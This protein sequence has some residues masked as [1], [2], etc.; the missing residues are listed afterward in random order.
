MRTSTRVALAGLFVRTILLTLLA[1]GTTVPVSA[2]PEPERRVALVIG[3]SDYRYTEKLRNPVNDATQIAE[4][5]RRLSFTVVAGMDL[6]A[7]Q[8]DAK[9][10]AFAQAVV[11]ADV[12]LV[13]YAGHG[14]QVGGQNYLMPIDA[15]IA[16]ERSAVREL[17]A[18]GDVMAEVEAKAKATLVFLDSC[19]NNPLQKNIQGPSGPRGESARGLARMEDRKNANTLLMFATAP[20]RT[21]EDGLSQHSPFTEA[22]LPHIEA[23]NIDVEVM[24]KRVVRD[25]LLATNDQQQ[26]ERLS[27]LR[28]EFQ[29]VASK[30]A[31]EPLTKQ[32]NQVWARE[33]EEYLQLK[34]STDV[35]LV[36]AFIDK[37]PGGIYAD[38]ARRR[39]RE[40]TSGPQ[41]P[42]APKEDPTL[43]CTDAMTIGTPEAYKRFI[44]KY[45]TH[46][47]ADRFRRQMM[48]GADNVAW[49][50]AERANSISEYERYKDLF[51][52]GLRVPIAKDR[53]AVLLAK[54]RGQ[55]I[56]AER[57][58][59]IPPVVSSGTACT[60][61]SIITWLERHGAYGA[62]KVDTSVY[63]DPVKWVVNG[64]ESTKS[65]EELSEDEVNF[66]N[67]FPI[68]NYTLKSA[69]TTLAQ[70]RC[71]MVMHVDSYK[72]R[73][74]GSEERTSLKIAFGIRLG[75]DG[76]LIVEQHI[77]VLRR[78]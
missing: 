75:M 61:Q 66:R 21:A 54:E 73:T 24:L 14:I 27:K 28:T 15:R 64:D 67:A 34:D 65:R 43:E 6:T 63:L 29:F 3:N 2:A 70:E 18:L 8:M 58:P 62:E 10:E 36:A 44:T 4:V 52:E 7:E 16:N 56:I 31:N 60:E 47:C 59:T 19:R 46:S 76:P 77:D 48:I 45:P 23:P 13:F 55:T 38:A 78:W 72:K 41:Q 32:P 71:T 9:R 53:I 51:P 40:L 37:Y 30:A 5:L 20:G 22:L 11:G 1:A 69:S 68:R 74:N 33:R 26:P 42:T 17:V 49:E 57:V 50:R 25:V 12:A 35:N 39:L